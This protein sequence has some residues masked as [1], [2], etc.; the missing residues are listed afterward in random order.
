MHPQAES[1]L[2]TWYET[3]SNAEWASMADVR[4][5]FR[6]A[7]PIDSERIVFNIGGNNYRLVVKVW[8]PAMT[9]WVKFIGTHR[10]Y[11]R[12]DVTKL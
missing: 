12:V 6:S 7:D 2:R 4:K 3:V 8:F 5:T 10:D 1:P 11:D 9:L